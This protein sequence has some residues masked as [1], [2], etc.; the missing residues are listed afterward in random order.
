M[1]TVG[2]LAVPARTV[3]GPDQLGADRYGVV[4]DDAG[5]VALVRAGDPAGPPADRA[6]LLVLPAGMGLTELADSPA[7]TVLDA[8]PELPG[9][10][11][12]DPGGE[13][14][15]V[16]PVEV[17]DEFLG[18]GRYQPDLS[19]MGPAG[20]GGDIDV[21]GDPRLPLARLRCRA[22]GC[23]YLNTLSYLD[24][25]HPPRCVNPDLPEHALEI[26]GV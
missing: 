14:T 11:I 9:F 4:C 17:L 6:P 16:L 18:S 2:E 22:P 20:H 24:L 13:P 3:D 15:G 8:Y 1:T 23:G 10:V 19:V 5:P 26:T 12:V 7:L 25:A 21:P